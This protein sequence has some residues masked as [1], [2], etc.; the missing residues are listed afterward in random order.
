[1]GTG[2][3]PHFGSL[4]RNLPGIGAPADESAVAP[5]TQLGPLQGVGIC[6]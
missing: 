3:D 4:Q 5:P 6:T 2:R 1:M